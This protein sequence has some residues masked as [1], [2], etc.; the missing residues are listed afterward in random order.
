MF[1]KTRALIPIYKYGRDMGGYVSAYL[2][3]IISYLYYI[4]CLL[5]LL[6]VLLETGNAV[7]ICCSSSV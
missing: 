3:P 6:Y 7:T 4:D 5:L 2:R 1:I